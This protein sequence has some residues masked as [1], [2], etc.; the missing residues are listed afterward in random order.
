MPKISW[1]NSQR[2]LTELRDS[3]FEENISTGHDDYFTLVNVLRSSNPS[4]RDIYKH[5]RLA[6]ARY[7]DLERLEIPIHR[8][9]A[10][11]ASLL[12]LK[13]LYNRNPEIYKRLI[14]NKQ[15]VVWEFLGKAHSDLEKIYNKGLEG[16]NEYQ[17]TNFMVASNH[18]QSKLQ[19]ISKSYSTL[20][21]LERSLGIDRY[22]GRNV[23]QDDTKA[24]SSIITKIKANTQHDC[25]LDKNIFLEKWN[26][27]KIYPSILRMLDIQKPDDEVSQFFPNDQSRIIFLLIDALGFTQLDWFNRTVNQSNSISPIPQNIFKWLQENVKIKDEFI[28]A[29]NLVS[30]TGSCL[31]TI[32][33]GAIPSTT[34]ITGSYMVMD[35]HHLNVLFGKGLGVDSRLSRKEI[36]TIYRNNTNQDLKPF[37][38]IALENGVDVRVFH[39][40]GMSFSSLAEYTYGKLIDEK[41]VQP[42]DPPDRIFTDLSK[43]TNGWKDEINQKKLAVLYYPL[44]D[45]FG[46][47]SGP[48]TQFQITSL[49]KLNFILSHFLVDLAVNCRKIFDGKT[50]LVI[51]ADHG[52]Y[53]S[54]QNVISH[55]ILQEI[56]GGKSKCRDFKFIYDNRAMHIFGIEKEDIDR[57]QGLFSEYF[58][59]NNL[60]VSILTKRDKVFRELFLTR[61]V[62]PQNVPD[63]LLQFIGGG[64]FYHNKNL[65]SHH[66]LYGAH[67]GLSVEEIFVPFYRYSLTPEIARLLTSYSF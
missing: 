16:R 5:T 61:S 27:S 65:P 44:I 56:L 51:T 38:E 54:S 39:G 43:F 37:P 18:I 14:T 42:I 19:P 11:D 60:N 9:E 30:I 7:I 22:F 23:L 10:V 63:M 24:L 35:G 20:T 40:G 45:K 62:Y 26:L 52:M 55:K 50:S 1:E 57:V 41:R 15:G 66:F 29:S 67:G 36:E 12:L 46:H 2:I 13:T 3:F 64:V 49:M 48:Y 32:F 53:E 47:G 17:F 21:N 4:T 28:L 34:G 8:R 58:V 31:P 59:K 25:E 6:K 33:T